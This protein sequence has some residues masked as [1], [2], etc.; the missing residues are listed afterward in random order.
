MAYAG[1]TGKND[2]VRIHF[3]RNNSGRINSEI[4][5]EYYANNK[6]QAHPDGYYTKLIEIHMAV[7]PEINNDHFRFLRFG[8]I[9]GGAEG[10]YKIKVGDMLTCG[11]V[12]S[13]NKERYSGDREHRWN[14]I[15]VKLNP[16]M[17]NLFNKTISFSYYGVVRDSSDEG[18]AHRAA[19]LIEK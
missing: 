4:T 9:K 18:Y 5:I 6:W 10:G 15:N 12:V 19:F 16:E 11:E 13:I 3:S 1:R 8:D 17:E 7:S 14:S 2:G